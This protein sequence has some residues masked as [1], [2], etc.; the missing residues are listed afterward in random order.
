[1]SVKHALLALL[2]RGPSPAYQLKKDFDRATGL[3]WPLNM[4]QVSTTLQRLARDGLVIQ[5][6]AAQDRAAHDRVPHD[7]AAQDGAAQ[8]G[9]AAVDAAPVRPWRLT[10]EGRAELARWWSAPVSREHRGRDELVVKL[11]LAV[12]VPGVDV[13]ALV[14][15]QRSAM[16]RLLH[17]VTRARRAVEPGQ[18]AAR[19]V[20]DNHIF[21]AEAELRWLDAVE[22]EL[23]K[24]SVE[25]RD[26]AAATS[27]AGAARDG[28]RGGADTAPGA[29]GDAATRQAA[30]LREGETVGEGALA[31]GTVAEAP[32]WPVAAAPVGARA[33]ETGRRGAGAASDAV[34]AAPTRPTATAYAGARDGG[35]WTEG[36]LASGAVVGG[37]GAGR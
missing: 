10:A 5:D 21:A 35:R 18:L 25:A 36:G 19:L 7:R 12:T 20:L 27:P 23:A 6:E 11:A 3:T 26:A 4:G 2:A 32:A 14:Q 15:R 31:A 24:A 22:G 13:A 16:Q 28:A 1:M 37:R 30:P 34:A 9:G 33:G 8:H 17:D 29:A